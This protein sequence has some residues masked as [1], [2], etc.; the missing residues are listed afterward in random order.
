MQ[1]LPDTLTAA[2][3]LQRVALVCPALTEA[4]SVSLRFNNAQG[5]ST[6]SSLARDL[7]KRAHSMKENS[8]LTR[9]A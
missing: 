6:I 8:D 7:P 1:H 5:S 9:D 4:S 2:T 3:K